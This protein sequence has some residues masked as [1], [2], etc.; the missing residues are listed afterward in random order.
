VKRAVLVAAIALLGAAPFR[1]DQQTRWPQFRFGGGLNVVVVNPALPEEPA[2]RFDGGRKGTS[3]SPVVAGTTILIASND[4]H[5]YA[6][7]GGTGRLRWAFKGSDEL[8]SQPVYQNG[9]VYAGAGNSEAAIWAPPYY[10]LIGAGKNDLFALDLKTGKL[11]WR[12][13]LPGSGMVTPA[14]VGSWL[15]QANGAAMVYAV[16]ARTGTYVWRSYV[17]SDADMS[18]TLDGG[19]G[20]IYVAGGFPNAVYALD[21]RN[22][23]ILWRHLFNMYDTALSD[24]PLASDASA[25]YGM[26]VRQLPPMRMPYVP[27]FRRAQQYAYAL[28]RRTGRFLWVRPLPHVVGIVPGANESAIPLLDAGTLYD[29]SGLT[30][31]VSAVDAR[32]G[33]TRWQLHTDG[34]VRGAI[35][36][37]DRI[38]YFGDLHGTLWAVDA[39]TGHPIGKIKTDVAFNVGSPIILNDSLVIGSQN[40][41]V[42]AVPLAAIRSSREIAGVTMASYVLPLFVAF[43]AIVALLLIALPLWRREV[44]QARLGSRWRGTS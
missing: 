23:T 12:F 40:G 27:A 35:A 39:A 20:K 16:D 28:D 25:L 18:Q 33:K 14:L 24:C 10:K 30:G 9:I 19:D 37:R 6:L 8:M 31:I 42:I 2:W 15:I 43:A 32:T 17:N 26:Y 3:A 1:A 13:N 44:R 34:P 41:P 38:L 21:A 4:H 7:D 11:I 36:E 29:G 5:L 22:G